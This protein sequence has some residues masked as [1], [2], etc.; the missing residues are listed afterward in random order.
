MD[1]NKI[2]QSILI[3]NTR[4]RIIQ[5]INSNVLPPS[6]MELIMRDA[7]LEISLKA[8]EMLKNDFDEYKNQ[9]E[10]SEQEKKETES[11]E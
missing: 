9:T 10:Q 1:N 8:Q 3:A 11:D 7:Y 2:P 4:S 5:I 6:I